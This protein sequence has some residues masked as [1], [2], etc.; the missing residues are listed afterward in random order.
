MIS[1]IIPQ[2]SAYSN[3]KQKRNVSFQ[4]NAAKLSRIN[5]GS[6]PD[7]FIAKVKVRKN[8][9]ETFVNIFKKTLGKHAENYTIQNDKNEVLGNVNLVIIKPEPCSWMPSW[10]SY[11]FVD[12]LR[13][14]SLPETPYH[15][16][17]LE[18]HKDIGTRL[19]QIAL[20]RSEEEGCKGN[21]QLITVSQAR[22]W[23][24]N[25]IGMQ[26][27]YPQVPGE[28]YFNNPNQLYLPDKNKEALA[29]LRG[30]LG[31]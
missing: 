31:F 14:F 1:A 23:Y 4:H 26:Q 28:P 3:L 13:N 5:I 2:I 24:K 29:K 17:S 25:I 27:M 10:N 21:I 7:G 22:D 11:I 30:G 20:R 18:Y 15:N 9:D 6:C 19:I 16:K 12:E 8:C